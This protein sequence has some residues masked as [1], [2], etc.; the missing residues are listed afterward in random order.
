MQPKGYGS[1]KA[2]AQGQRRALLTITFSY[3]GRACAVI[4][5][6]PIPL[7]PMSAKQRKRKEDTKGGTS[8]LSRSA[9]STPAHR[10]KLHLTSITYI[11]RRDLRSLVLARGLAPPRSPWALRSPIRLL[12]FCQPRS[13]GSAC[14]CPPHV[15]WVGHVVIGRRIGHS[16]CSG[17]GAAFLGVKSIPTSFCPPRGRAG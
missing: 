2:A 3:P 12:L 10:P 15:M 5:R 13:M 14:W 1:G 6:H 11:H 16:S 4:V 8:Y 9:S 7:P 17:R